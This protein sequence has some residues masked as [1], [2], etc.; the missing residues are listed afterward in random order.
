MTAGPRQRSQVSGGS[1]A[2]V[3]KLSLI[4]V[5]VVFGLIVLGGVVRA[6]DSGLGC[7]DWP[8]CHGKLIPELEKHTLIEYSHRLTASIAGL[9][10]LGLAAWSWRSFRGVPALM[11]PAGLALA[12]IVVQAGLGGAA[13]LNELPPEIVAVH[14]G[15][16][17]MILTVLGLFW[18]TACALERGQTE[19]PAS[20]HLRR[21]SLTTLAALFLLM[22]VGSYVSGAGYSLACNG[23][24]LCNGQ[25]IPSGGASVGTAFLHRLLALL[26]GVLL[27]LLLRQA[28]RER[29]RLRGAAVLAPVALTVYLLQVLIGAANVWTRLAEPVSAA[30]LAVGV[31]LWA[32]VGLLAL[33][34]LRA[35]ELLPRS[36]RQRPSRQLAGL[37]R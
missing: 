15:M 25:V 29:D 3:R 28:L 31:L 21:L 7:P 5:A 13:V 32:I 9:L 20:R 18:L 30:H 16:A 4:T 37:A 27:L 14:L 8:T 23:W 24:P 17:L 33:R 6:T 10:V 34:A 12:L 1:L 26:V 36:W 19:P 2:G 11:L 35:D 22:L